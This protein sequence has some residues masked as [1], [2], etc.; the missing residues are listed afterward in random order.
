[1]FYIT[2][3]YPTTYC[4][5]N[6]KHNFSWL[7]AEGRQH[8]DKVIENV[9]FPHFNHSNSLKKSLI[10]RRAASPNDEDREIERMSCLL[11]KSIFTVA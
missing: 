5:G 7:S 11:N 10:S 6:T 3:D 4:R 8:T 1:M 9:T 2:L